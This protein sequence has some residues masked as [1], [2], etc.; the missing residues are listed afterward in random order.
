MFGRCVCFLVT[1]VALA[2]MPA[3]SPSLAVPKASAR[4]ELQQLVRLP[5]LDFGTPLEFHSRFGFS[6]FPDPS[7]AALDAARVL[8]EV[9]GAPEDA[10]LHLQ[11]ARIFDAQGDATA[12]M[13]QYSRVIDLYRKRLEVS[14]EETK[15]LAGLG[16]ALAALGRFSEAQA[17]LERAENPSLELWLARA[18]LYRERAWFAAAGEA[19]RYA[20]S[21]FLDQLVGLVR[22]GPNPTQVE[23]SKRFLRLFDEALQRAF[24]DQ[25]DPTMEIQRLIERAV[26]RSL[27]N[28]LETAFAQ[29]QNGELKSRA[30][31]S[32]IFTGQA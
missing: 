8:K 15:S 2:T 29:I 24:H 7:M 20:T 30:L 4:H 27:A 6:V 16:E 26:F 25:V 10:G 21:S 5:V 18:R 22:N 1:V 12:A 9:K 32:S 14:P 11:A 17:V 13:R 23:D 3:I 28:A 19:Q 31:H